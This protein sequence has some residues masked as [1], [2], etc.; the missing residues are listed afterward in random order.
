[1][2][3]E[4]LYC[5]NLDCPFY[6]VHFGRSRLVKNGTT[7]GQRQALCRACGSSLALT[8]GTPD[9]DLEHAPALFELAIRAL[10]EGNS[11]R[12]T[13]R[14][15]QVDKDTVC[16]WL[17][18]AAQQC[19]LVTLYLWQQLPLRECQLDE[20]WSFVHTKDE[21]LSWAKTS[22]D[23]YGDAWVW[24]AFAPE[25]RLVVAF[26]VG[27]RTQAEANL[28]LERVAHVTTDLI[29]FFT[30]DHLAE[31]R[32]ALRHVYG[33]WYQPPRRGT[34]GPSPHP[35][36]VPHKELSY[37]QV[38]KTRERGRVVAVDHHVVFGDVQGIATLLAS[39]PTSAT[40]NTSFVEREN[41][42]LRQHNRRLTRKTNAF[43]KELPWLEKQLWLSLAYTHLVLPHDSLRQELPMAEPTRGTGSPRRWQPRTPAMAAGLTDHVWTTD[44]LLSYRVPA[45]FVDQ[46]DQLEHL[47]PQPEPIYQGN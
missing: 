19:R 41:L 7:R 26:V 43:S 2:D 6:G 42:A 5:P 33:E 14:I 1:M 44:E 46:L 27:K 9:C 8:Y 23:T 13:A 28:W 31:Y 39:L 22:R 47:F 3:W 20:L 11:I 38:V 32:T 17:D 45:R 10:A 36:R 16:T 25:W 30:S 4:T 35:R 15:I 12:A 18:R 34:R 24:V 21:H 29:P 37:A 40:I